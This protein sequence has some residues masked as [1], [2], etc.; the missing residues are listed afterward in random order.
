MED[1]E[2]YFGILV[3]DEWLW[4]SWM[5]GLLDL[6]IGP[7]S[8]EIFDTYVKQILKA[9]NYNLYSQSGYIDKLPT[10]AKLTASFEDMSNV[11]T[12]IEEMDFEVL[13]R[14]GYAPGNDEIKS[15]FE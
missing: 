8:D 5:A 12:A 14:Y 15:L 2:V 9:K 7:E 10:N 1:K 4:F 13:N 3:D 6:D 11:Q